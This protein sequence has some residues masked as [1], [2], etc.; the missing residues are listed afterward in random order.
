MKNILLALVCLVAA[1]NPLWAQKA[2]D[3]GAGAMLGNPTGVTGKLWLSEAHALDAGLG[4][5]THFTA[6]ADYLWHT[7]TVVPQPAQGKL[8]LYFGAGGQVRAFHDSEFGV[9]A[10][11]GVSY[12][13]PRSPVEI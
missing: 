4:V 10:V 13:L 1:A 3:L 5:S 6:Y 12:W 8:G 7:W 11:A 2:G 9:R